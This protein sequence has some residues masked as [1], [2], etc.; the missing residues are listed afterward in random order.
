MLVAH[1]DTLQE[2]LGSYL[3]DE[4]RERHAELLKHLTPGPAPPCS[5]L[6][7]CLDFR[8]GDKK[9]ITDLA[10]VRL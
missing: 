5:L 10:W 3:R 7:C 9:P 8:G 6:W 1:N 4:A 2:L